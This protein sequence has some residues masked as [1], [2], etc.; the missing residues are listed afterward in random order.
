MIKEI[1]D[2]IKIRRIKRMALRK[3]VIRKIDLAKDIDNLRSSIAK[4]N[5]DREGLNIKIKDLKHDL[6]YRA[7]LIVQMYEQ[8]DRF[9]KATGYTATTD[10]SGR[11]IYVKMETKPKARTKPKA[12]DKSKLRKNK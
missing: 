6:K 3:R 4:I 8:F 11:V 12:N 10:G 1:I 2:K 9:V 7:G 5:Y